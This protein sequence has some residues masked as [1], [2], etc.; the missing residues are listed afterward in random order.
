MSVQVSMHTV[1]FFRFNWKK[2]GHVLNLHLYHPGL[3]ALRILAAFS[4]VIPV[5][6]E[7]NCPVSSNPP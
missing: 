4:K 2:D 1:H 3:N 6:D 7:T 5:K